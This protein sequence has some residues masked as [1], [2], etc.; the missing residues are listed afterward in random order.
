[1]RSPGS[2]AAEDARRHPVGSGRRDP[3]GDI[4]RLL[5]Q[6]PRRRGVE[7][8]RAVERSGGQFE[9]RA[10]D[11]H[12]FHLDEANLRGG[13]ERHDDDAAGMHDDLPRSQAAVGARLLHPLHAKPARLEQHAGGR[14][15]LGSH[16]GGGTT[17]A[18]RPPTVRLAGSASPRVCT[19]AMPSGPPSRG[20]QQVEVIVPTAVPALATVAPGAG[21]VGA[22]TA[23]VT[24]RRLTCPS[25]SMRATVS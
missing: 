5:G 18:G 15:R 23:I 1:M 6:F 8:L 13:H 11:G 2:S 3:P 4:A 24:S 20:D 25:E 17:R 22:E 14:H 9:Q 10:A 12:P 7:R 16:A 21:G 19:I